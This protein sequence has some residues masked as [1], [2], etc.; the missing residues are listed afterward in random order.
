MA[1]QTSLSTATFRENA[2]IPLAVLDGTLSLQNVELHGG[3][4]GVE[5]PNQRGVVCQA[6][7][8]LE[9]RDAEVRDFAGGGIY[10]LSGCNVTLADVD[11]ARTGDPDDSFD[12][13]GIA[14]FDDATLDITRTSVGQ[15]EQHG[16]VVSGSTATIRESRIYRNVAAVARDLSSSV[17]LIDTV[18]EDNEQDE[19]VCQSQCFDRPEPLETLAALPGF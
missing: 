14:V 7:S 15:S 13:N 8:T 4:P 18:F 6:A 2:V 5:V 12:G 17:E 16:I 3:G 10:G 19:V 11:I 9:V 1:G